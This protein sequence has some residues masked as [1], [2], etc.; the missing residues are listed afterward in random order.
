M[1]NNTTVIL[2][3]KEILVELQGNVEAALRAA[4]ATDGADAGLV[5]TIEAIAASMDPAT[6]RHLTVRNDPNRVALSQVGVTAYLNV[7]GSDPSPSWVSQLT[8]A[9]VGAV[10]GWVNP[11]NEKGKRPALSWKLV[12]R[13]AGKC[14]RGQIDPKTGSPR[15]KSTSTKDGVTPSD[16]EPGEVA[17]VMK[18][19]AG[20]IRLV[21]PKGTS[22]ETARG[23]FIQ[24]LELAGMQVADLN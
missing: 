17:S 14:A 8:N 4:N 6:L 21:I 22:V 13:Y 11:P 18:D 1:G 10:N 16:H 9:L 3:D 7:N 2:F 19:R 15:D 12:W 5:N 20:A 23:L 24:A